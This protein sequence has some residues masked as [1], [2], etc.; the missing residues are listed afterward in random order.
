MQHAFRPF[1]QVD[2]RFEENFEAKVKTLN[3]TPALG[4]PDNWTQSYAGFGLQKA[5]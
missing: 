4:F 1:W 2:D 5:F 3:I